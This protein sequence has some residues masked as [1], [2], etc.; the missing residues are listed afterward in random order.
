MVEDEGFVAFMALACPF[1]ELPCRRTLSKY[2]EELYQKEHKSFAFKNKLEEEQIKRGLPTR[3][4]IQD[5]PTRWGRTRASTSS[6]L[7]KEDK[8]QDA[9]DDKGS[10]VFVHGHDQ[11]GPEEEF[12]RDQKL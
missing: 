1:Y 7:D 9:V 11:L 12:K 2:R 5:V 8:D 6:F 4:L 3:A 10:D